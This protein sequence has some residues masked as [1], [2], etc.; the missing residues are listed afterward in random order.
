MVQLKEVFFYPFCYTYNFFKRELVAFNFIFL[1]EYN[2]FTMLY[3]FLLYNKVN[4]PW[5]WKVKVKSLSRVR[6]FV[7]TWTV[8]YQAPP[9]M[10]FS[11][12]EYW[13]GLPFPSPGDRPN[14]GIVPESS[15]LQARALPSEPPGNQLYIC[16]YALPLG[17]PSYPPHPTPLGHH[18]E[19]SWAP[20]RMGEGKGGTTWESSTDIYTMCK[21]HS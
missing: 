8:A 15:T 9:R 12:Q 11:R 5:K 1:L 3:S 18:R 16:I 4:Q 2:C 19:L 20:C 13:S 10:G 21:I 6:L 7:T 17:P 14:P